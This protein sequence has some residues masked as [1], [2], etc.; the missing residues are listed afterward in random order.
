[1]FRIKCFVVALVSF[2]AFSGVALSQPLSKL[3]PSLRSLLLSDGGIRMSQLR[4]VAHTAV[5]NRHVCAL[6]RMS[7]ESI[8]PLSVNGCRLLAQIGD[9]C[10]VDIPVS[11]LGSLA[12]DSRVC[13]IEAERGNMLQLDS[14][15]QYTDASA[16]YT[17]Q[18]LPQAYT[19]RGVVVGVMDVGF[20][21]THPTFRDGD[22]KLRISRVWDQ[23][24]VD[25]V[26]SA[27]YVGA[28]YTGERSILDY[29]HSRDGMLMYHGTHTLGIVAGS[30]ASTPYMG[31][32]PESDF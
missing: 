6:V 20:D 9:I 21:L 23:L 31:M 29:A 4:H 3:S 2:L 7:D 24:S 22:G 1:M 12:A 15:R 27:M 13:R 19:G 16:I 26:G 25:T 18:M 14:M 10:V 11:R 32:A 17:G 8:E 30:G 5:D 28:E